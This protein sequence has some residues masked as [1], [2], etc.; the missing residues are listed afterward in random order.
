MVS[1]KNLKNITTF[2]SNLNIGDT[3][4][5]LLSGKKGLVTQIC[6]LSRTLCEYQICFD[7]NVYVWKKE[8]E[9]TEEKDWSSCD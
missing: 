7:Y 9:L 2:E 3:V 1:Q 6:F 5:C 8:V 4:Y